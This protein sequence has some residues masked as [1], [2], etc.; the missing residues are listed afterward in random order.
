[1]SSS[2]NVANNLLTV[3]FLAFGAIAGYILYQSYKVGKEIEQTVSDITQTMPETG[4]PG[5]VTGNVA[6][7]IQ[8]QQALHPDDP[9]WH[10]SNNPAP[11]PTP[12]IASQLTAPVQP[13]S[14]TSSIASW[15]AQQPSVSGETPISPPPIAVPTPP[16]SAPNVASQIAQPLPPAGAPGSVTANTAA[17]IAQ[18]RR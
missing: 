9:A 4:A 18:Q 2:S 7:W 11:V 14:G 1:M 17:W 13:G 12:S 6:N 15:A 10:P 16:T 5:S 8:Q 3:E